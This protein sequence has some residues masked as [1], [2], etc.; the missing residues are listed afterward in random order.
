MVRTPN[1]PDVGVR[2]R[3]AGDLAAAAALARL[4]QVYREIGMEKGMPNSDDVQWNEQ[5]R[6]WD[7][8]ALSYAREMGGCWRPWVTG[9]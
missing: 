5:G 3:S 1:G 8:V 2:A 9:V 7:P 6:P 4:L